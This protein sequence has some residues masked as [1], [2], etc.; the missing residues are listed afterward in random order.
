MRSKKGEQAMAEQNKNRLRIRLH[1]YDEDIEVVINR[2]DEEFYR[3]AAKLITERY[4][5]YA[6]AYKGRKSDHI[7]SLM[8]LIDIAL[9]Y[10]KE[11]SNNDTAP[12]VDVFAQ[13]TKEI[14]NAL[15]ERK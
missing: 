13:L 3:L 2:D 4:N 10:Q 11:R 14:E 15:G 12:F 9:M 5:A 8:T 1:V 7:I 6:Q